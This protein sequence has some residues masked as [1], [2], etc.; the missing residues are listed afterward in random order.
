MTRVLPQQTFS[1][2]QPSKSAPSPGHGL[3]G[4]K[5]C[6]KLVKPPRFEPRP[7]H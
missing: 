3:K 4:D 5:D 7:G 6:L 2:F 1:G